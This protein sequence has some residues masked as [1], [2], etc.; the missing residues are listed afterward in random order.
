MNMD[1]VFTEIEK[2]TYNVSFG[3]LSIILYMCIS[4]LLLLL[5]ILSTTIFIG[6]LIL[7]LLF[8]VQILMLFS[9]GHFLF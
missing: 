7:L 2:Y 4:Y 6:L 3:V 9:C 1:W 8:I 5:L